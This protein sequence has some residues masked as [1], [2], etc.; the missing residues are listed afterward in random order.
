MVPRRPMPPAPAARTGASA[1][2]S[3]RDSRPVSANT[4]SATKSSENQMLIKA[5]WLPPV[6]MEGMAGPASSD[7]IHLEADIHAT[8]GNRNG[9]A[10]DEF[11]PYLIVPLHHRPEGAAAKAVEP[12]HGKMSPMVARDGLHYGATIAMPGPGHY[13]LTYAIEPPSAGWPSRRSGDGRRTMVEA[14]RGLVRL[15]FSRTSERLRGASSATP[16]ARRTVTFRSKARIG[17]TARRAVGQEGGLREQAVGAGVDRQ[18]HRLLTEV[19]P[20]QPER[21]DPHRPSFDRAPGAA[22]HRRLARSARG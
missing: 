15:G 20:D 11:V 2:P 19:D 3:A 14:V 12:I 16:S 7:L 4:R 13:K 1:P 6:Q 10:K 5:V 22:W 8:E 18:R 9:F 21:H 17:E